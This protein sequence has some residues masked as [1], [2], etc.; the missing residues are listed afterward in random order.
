MRHCTSWIEPCAKLR[1][2][3]HYLHKHTHTH[4]TIHDSIP[5]TPVYMGEGGE[6]GGGHLQGGP[7][8]R[9]DLINGHAWLCRT[10]LVKGLSVVVA[11]C[12]YVYVCKKMCIY[13]DVY[14]HIYLCIYIVM[15][16]S[17]VVAWCTYVCVCMEIWCTSV[18]V[19][20]E[21]GICMDV[22]VYIHIYW[23]IYT[24]L[25]TGLSA[26]VA[27]CEISIVKGSKFRV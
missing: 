23:C 16:L 14:V 13:M 24:W 5:V 17:A 9:G 25:V 22:Y 2:W 1:Q 27:W 8:C 12:T 6:K 18:Y 4:T 20:M 19:C 7:W 3:R 15:G 10:R 11:W 21:I 26:V